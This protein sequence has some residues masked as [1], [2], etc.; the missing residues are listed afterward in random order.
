[1]YRIQA[2]NY[3][4][5][6]HTVRNVRTMEERAQVIAELL[7]TGKYVQAGITWEWLARCG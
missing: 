4:D 7:A 6:Y 3:V 1:M 5:K 2:Y